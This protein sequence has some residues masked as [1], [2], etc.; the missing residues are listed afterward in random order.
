MGKAYNPIMVMINSPKAFEHKD[1]IKAL[2]GQW[3]SESKRW[4]I[5]KTKYE[6]IM[7]VLEPN[8]EQPKR[9]RAKKC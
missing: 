9:G 5:D 1:K 8:R 7:N 4:W 6:S 3:D 2:G